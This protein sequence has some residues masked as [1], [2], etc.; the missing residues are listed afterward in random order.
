MQLPTVKNWQ[1]VSPS[2]RQFWFG[3]KPHRKISRETV[4]GEE[5]GAVSD[6]VHVDE[7]EVYVKDVNRD[8]KEY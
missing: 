1:R 6:D 4:G 3:R 2:T 8:G 5:I 7:R